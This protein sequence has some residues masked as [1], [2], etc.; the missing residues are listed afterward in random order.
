MSVC[1]VEYESGRIVDCGSFEGCSVRLFEQREAEGR[2]D[3][4]QIL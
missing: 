2:G 1:L 4:E 3:L